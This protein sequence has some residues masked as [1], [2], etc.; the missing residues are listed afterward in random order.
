MDSI[1]S[2]LEEGTLY[3]Y[4]FFCEKCKNQFYKIN[5][6]KTVNRCNKCLSFSSII[7]D[8]FNIYIN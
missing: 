7:N 4:I 5:L 2:K 6:S 8:L 1:L 3:D